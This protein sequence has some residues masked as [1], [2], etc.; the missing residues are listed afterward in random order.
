[1]A[2]KEGKKVLVI[3]GHPLRRSFCGVLKRSYI[4]GAEEAGAQIKELN[5]GELKF[6]PLLKNGYKK[7][8]KFES[9][10]K[11]S[12]EYIAWADHLVIIYPT[13]WGTMPAL[14]KGF[15]DRVFEPNFAFKFRGKTS[16]L[17]DRL[18]KGK[19][20][21]IITTMDGPPWYYKLF[22][23]QPGINIIK[24]GILNFCGVKPVNV[25]IYGS[26]K[27]SSKDQRE[28]WIVDVIKKGQK[29]K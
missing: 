13:W 26:V 21:H 28:D 24:K 7:K 27:K 2:K 22:L 10:L 25:S 19:S 11:K 14:L 15:F 23:R 6:D 8:Q 20:A 4:V 29:L 5:L 3:L 18:L 17:W 16:L 12:Q 1:M 9:D